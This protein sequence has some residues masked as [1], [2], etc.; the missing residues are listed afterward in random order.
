MN[1]RNQYLSGSANR[2]W[3]I[4]ALALAVVAALLAGARPGLARGV[5]LSGHWET[6]VFL[7]KITA[8]VEQNGEAL[9]GVVYVHGFDG[10]KDSYHFKGTCRDGHIEAAHRQGHRFEG[11]VT[12]DGGIRG[13]LTTR[14]GKKLSLQCPGR[15]LAPNQK[16]E[17][18]G[19]E[20]KAAPTGGQ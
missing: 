6:R 5:D 17:G 20:G 13:I 2:S 16:R 4:A 14:M 19:R 10:K 11:T 15:E 7:H 3:R 12:P 8:R 18:P 1:R 9:K